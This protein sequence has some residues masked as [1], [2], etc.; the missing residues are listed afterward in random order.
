MR[1]QAKEKDIVR[2]KEIA[3]LKREHESEIIELKQTAQ[4]THELRAWVER[5]GR[6]SRVTQQREQDLKARIMALNN[7][8]SEMNKDWEAVEKKA[9]T[10]VQ[11]TLLKLEEQINQVNSK[12]EYEKDHDSGRF[13][14]LHFKGMGN[15]FKRRTRTYVR[16]PG[17]KLHE[18]GVFHSKNVNVNQASLELHHK[19]KILNW[20]N[21]GRKLWNVSI[22]ALRS[23][24]RTLTGLF[25]VEM[26]GGDTI[27]YN[28]T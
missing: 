19:D 7:T 16:K 21:T 2:E 3:S 28:T 20:R 8:V 18:L 26:K 14:E 23:A 15:C 6:E 13:L 10:Q 24:L 4:M 17:D 1:L 9:R 5:A 12:L 27:Y 22:T 11:G 25:Q